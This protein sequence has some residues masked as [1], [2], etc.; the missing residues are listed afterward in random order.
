M[1]CFDFRQVELLNIL[2]GASLCEYNLLGNWTKDLKQESKEEKI[3]SMSAG[4]ISTQL[5]YFILHFNV[6]TAVILY[7]MYLLNE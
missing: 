5:C 4:K 3:I 1:D 2:K 7:F 6:Y